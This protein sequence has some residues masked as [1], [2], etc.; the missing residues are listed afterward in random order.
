MA[1]SN[2]CT[3]ALTTE[4]LATEVD[5]HRRLEH[6]EAKGGKHSK[7]MLKD[8]RLQVFVGHP[9]RSVREELELQGQALCRGLQLAHHDNHLLIHAMVTTQVALEVVAENMEIYHKLILTLYAF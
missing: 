1:C 3:S 7:H 8:F 9:V 5:T 6:A 2:A 4:L